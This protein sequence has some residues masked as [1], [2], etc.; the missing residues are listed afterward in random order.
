MRRR[1]VE[2]A[3]AAAVNVVATLAHRVA[4]PLAHVAFVPAVRA[5]EERDD[6]C[7]VGEESGERPWLNN[8][9]LAPVNRVD[10]VTNT[11]AA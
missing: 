11:A 2:H 6:E 4:P 1:A 8:E 3:R 5:L 10:G 9:T 7:I